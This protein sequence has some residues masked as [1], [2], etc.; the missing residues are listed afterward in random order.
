MMLSAG[1]A[2][3][4]HGA[5]KGC[6]RRE[7]AMFFQQATASTLLHQAACGGG[8]QTSFASVAGALPRPYFVDFSKQRH[9]SH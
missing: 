5:A 9:F 4:R 8:R 3:R 2:R 7:A 1:F 6:D